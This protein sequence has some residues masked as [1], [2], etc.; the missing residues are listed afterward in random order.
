[1]SK[2]KYKSEQVWG[3]KLGHFSYQ[4]VRQAL[5]QMNLG[6]SQPQTLLLFERSRMHIYEIKP[7]RSNWIKQIILK[8]AFNEHIPC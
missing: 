5:C 1:M 3:K 4:S 2:E 7:F 6:A 8:M